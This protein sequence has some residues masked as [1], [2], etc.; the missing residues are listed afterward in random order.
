MAKKMDDMTKGNRAAHILE[1]T[2]LIVKYIFALQQNATAQNFQLIS[3]NYIY[4]LEARSN[5][6][7]HFRH[8]VH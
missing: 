8:P 6:C 7:T 4:I 1:V 5:S 3:L 2:A